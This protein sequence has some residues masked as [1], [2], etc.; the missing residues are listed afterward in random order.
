MALSRG[1]APVVEVPP[2]SQRSHFRRW[3]ARFAPDARRPPA[4]FAEQCR[5]VVGPARRQDFVPI[6]H[7][8]SLALPR[9]IVGFG[10]V[11][12]PRAWPRYKWF[13]YV[14]SLAKTL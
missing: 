14:V 12:R 2:P 6:T 13:S 8:G 10:S 4:Q 1:Q 5:P 9:S 3:A 7:A 11:W